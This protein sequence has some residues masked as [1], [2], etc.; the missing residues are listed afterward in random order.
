M[1]LDISKGLKID[2]E[3]L[4]VPGGGGSVTF[5]CPPDQVLSIWGWSYPKVPEEIQPIGVV[6]PDNVSDTLRENRVIDN[7]YT[8]LF[9]NNL[10]PGTINK[11]LPGIDLGASFV[12]KSLKI[13][14]SWLN[15]QPLDFNIQTSNDGVNWLDIETNLTSSGVDFDVDIF[16]VNNVTA[17][18]IRIFTNIGRSTQWVGAAEIEVFGVKDELVYGP[19]YQ[20]H[21]FVVGDNGSGFLQ[22]TN[23]SNNDT[24]ITV[25][26][27]V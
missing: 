19:I 6:D 5:S 24:D 3:T 7:N 14:W 25:N 2:K 20:D 21:N 9:Y 26:C 15:W 27:L 17:R 13:Y 8:Q 10:S 18:Y 22:I 12:L 4:N 23:Y 11:S 1:S 16:P